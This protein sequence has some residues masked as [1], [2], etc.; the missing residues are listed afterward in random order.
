MYR[1]SNF[2][3]QRNWVGVRDQLRTCSTTTT[4]TSSTQWCAALP[5]YSAEMDAKSKLN[6]WDLKCYRMGYDFSPLAHPC[7]CPCQPLPLRLRQVLKTSRGV[8]AAVWPISERKMGKRE[9][10]RRR[11]RGAAKTPSHP[12]IG[13]ALAL[14]QAWR[15]V[16]ACSSVHRL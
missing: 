11:E 13:T 4:G 3:D 14:R 16:N 8:G 15:L 10:E 2:H 1:V 7:P 6:D 5:G 9:K 12:K